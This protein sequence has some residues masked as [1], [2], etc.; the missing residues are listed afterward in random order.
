MN[1]GRLI[2]TEAALNHRELHKMLH[3]QPRFLV[4]Q[5][6]YQNQEDFE[7]VSGDFVKIKKN[8]ANDAAMQALG[9]PTPPRGLSFELENGEVVPL[10]KFKKTKEFGSTFGGPAENHKT[11]LQE[12]GVAII[13]DMMIQS[14]SD[15]DVDLRNY[16]PS[17][18]L[19][20]APSVD[21]VIEFLEGND[22]WMVNCTES[23]RAI[24]T[25][26]G[27]THNLSNYEIHQ[28]TPLVKAIKAL[29]AKL[30]GM[31]SRVSGDK[32]NPSDIFLI[33]EYNPTPEDTK[34][35]VSFNNYIHSHASN[36]PVIGISLK[37]DESL[38]G[39]FSLNNAIKGL[40][41][42][43]TIAIPNREIGDESIDYIGGLVKKV[44]SKHRSDSRFFFQSALK[45]DYTKLAG[46]V[47]S[48]PTR[49]VD[50]LAN[51]KAIGQGLGQNYIISITPSLQFLA[52]VDDIDAAISY[53]ALVAMSIDP[54]SCPHYKVQG[55]NLE[56]MGTH[57][58]IVLTAV[59][60][61]LNGDNDVIFDITANG[62]PLKLQLRSKGSLP[63]FIII[64]KVDSVGQKLIPLSRLVV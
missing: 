24:A 10:S 43:I 46:I 37:K 16:T 36:A 13:L 44:V 61:K 40:G 30:A 29:G 56:E 63:Q 48:M 14:G 45:S 28:G 47:S 54:R 35:V 9:G 2:L 41:A 39:S 19:K 15:S 60:I 18:K 3:G 32:W 42:N 31:G 50:I 62:V 38:H 25:H 64:K 27:E 22:S 17:D 33:R 57:M 11:N 20:I 52:G 6:K 1:I 55:A 7:L 21:A 5:T 26:L 8:A 12:S 23:A 34:D 4:F 53:A 51:L 59:R 58:E 49:L